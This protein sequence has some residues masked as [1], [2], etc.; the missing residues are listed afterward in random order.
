MTL[1]PRHPPIVPS[2]GTATIADLSSS[3]LASLDHEG[4]ESQNVLGLPP[5]ERACLLMVD[6]LGWEQLRDHPAA[7]PF[8]SEL[9]RNSRPI[10]AGFPATTATSLAS[11]GTGS[12]PGQHG[13]LGYKVLVPGEDILLNAL[14]W[15]SRVDPRQWQPLPTVYERAAAAGIAA[16][17]VARGSFRGRGLT[18]A[19]LRG[20]ELRPADSMGAL[21]AQGAA[22]LAENGRAFVTV[23]H[24]DL[25]S[26]GHMFGV[27]S[28]SWY[29]QLA[30]VDKLAEQLASAL[31]AQTCLYVTADHGMVDVGPDNRVDVDETQELRDGLALLGGEPRARHLYARPGA[32][33]DVLATWREMLGE[34]AWVLSRDEAIKEGWFGPVD[35]RM[36]DRIG[37]VVAAAADGFAVVA[38]RAEPSESALFAM[39]GSLTSAEQFVPAL[40]FTAT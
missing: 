21:A 33:V 27:G 8:L 40:S 17:H 5:A 31:P 6:G 11:L 7:A 25:D 14:R 13:M 4:P 19:A 36:A 2:Y 15:D 10:T 1:E 29:Y 18:I 34:R 24:G 16:V 38:S 3:I 28:D 37:D 20:A 23:Y 22:A 35:G 32:A 12:P 9:A 26:T 30:H 39:H